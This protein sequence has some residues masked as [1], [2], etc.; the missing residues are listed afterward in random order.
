MRCW[1][2]LAVV[3]GFFFVADAQAAEELIFLRG[4]DVFH[5]EVLES[6][7]DTV[8]I[9]RKTE[10]GETTFTVPADDVEPYFYYKVRDRDLGD[11]AMERLKLAGYAIRHDMFTRGKAQIDRARAIDPK[12]VEK[13]I[14]EHYEK[15]SEGIAQRLVKAAQRSLRGKSSSVRMHSVQ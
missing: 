6:T 12:G 4:G 9:S 15:I 14:E 5:G 13:F 10:T 2:A 3:C 1:I 11:D 8:K 7:W